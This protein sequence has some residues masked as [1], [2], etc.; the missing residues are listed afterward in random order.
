MSVN[1]QAA[2]SFPPP[3]LLI[4]RFCAE[5]NISKKEARD[6]FQETKKFLV[7]CANNR[8][9]NY[10]PSKEV[11]DMWH[12]FM[13]HSRDYFNFCELLGGYIH[14]QPTAR[15]RP[16]F[17]ENTLRAL[18]SFFGEVNPIYWYKVADCGNCSSSCH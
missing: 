7:L 5:N 13:L 14:H 1:V 2:M 11:D 18:V 17:Y 12:Q 10:S 15:P 4:K 3:A 6:I 9:A 16:Q 8:A